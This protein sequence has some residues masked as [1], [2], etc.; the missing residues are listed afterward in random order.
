MGSEDVDQKIG[1]FLH[2]KEIQFPELALSGRQD[3]RTFKHAAQL[4]VSGQ[5]LLDR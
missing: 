3:S 1:N 5:T 2:R 4:R